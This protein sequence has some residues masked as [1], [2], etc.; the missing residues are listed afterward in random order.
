MVDS[1]V[2]LASGGDT[3]LK[4][5]PPSALEDPISSSEAAANVNFLKTQVESWLAVL[6]NVFG[7]VDRDNRSK[8][9][10]VISAWAGIAGEEVP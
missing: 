1:N 6:F 8:I 4:K 2:A 3:K 10:D 9:G 7:T 5:L